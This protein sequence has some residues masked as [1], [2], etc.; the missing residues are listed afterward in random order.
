MVYVTNTGTHAAA[1]DTETYR[2]RIGMMKTRLAIPRRSGS[3]IICRVS[4]MHWRGFE[5]ADEPTSVDG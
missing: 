4:W 1:A 3:L 2:M 5:L